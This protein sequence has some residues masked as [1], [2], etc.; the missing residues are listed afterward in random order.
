[1]IAD[2]NYP[3]LKGRVSGDLM[4]ALIAP[5]LS[6]V[7]LMMGSGLFNT[8]APVRLELEGYD[9]E[10]IGLVAAALYGG[11]LI[12]ALKIERWIAQV[13]HIRSLATFAACFGLL[14][15]SSALWINPWFWGLL[16]F[17]AGICTAGIFIVIESWILM[18]SSPTNRGA[19]LSLYLGTFYGALALGQFLLNVSD[20]AGFWPFVIT[21]IFCILSILPL[22]LKTTVAPKIE[23]PARLSLREIFR[24]SPLG[25]LGGIV[26][27]MILAAVFGLVPVYAMQIGLNI[28]QISNLMAMIIFGGLTLQWP[29]G[30]WADRGRRR[31]ILYL[32]S[33]FSA[34][35]GFAIAWSGSAS[36][37]FLLLLA[38]AFG[39]FSFTLYPLS[40]A[41]TCEK[42]SD[43]KIIAATGG[44][45]LSYG[46]GAILG[47][48]IAPL[49]MDYFGTS[50]L[51][52]FLAAISL[53]FGLASLKR[54]VE[55]I[56][57]D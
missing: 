35:F 52:Y 25:F 12:G 14:S 54:P 7:L 18:R 8:F 32:S 13:G 46:I 41:Y 1:M 48:A 21:A 40:M 24:L 28:S 10:V 23:Q 16:R 11:I 31:Q 47:P 55:E 17:F 5:L 20:P 33:F 53:S 42:L 3:A 9:P 36:L 39:G 44:F 45:V 30:R 27:G 6:L 38:W 57:K 56:S 26:S 19:M 37:S 49:A 4:K 50:G 2:M 34:L 22:T 43:G 15:L 29:L 51:F